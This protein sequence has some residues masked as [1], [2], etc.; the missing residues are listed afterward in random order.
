M[1]FGAASAVPEKYRRILDDEELVGWLAYRISM[2]SI[3]PDDKAALASEFKTFVNDLANEKMVGRLVGIFKRARGKE[4]EAVQAALEGWLERTAESGY[5]SSLVELLAAGDFPQKMRGHAEDALLRGIEACGRAWMPRPVVELL[6]KGGLPEEIYIR[7]LEVAGK[8]HYVDYARYMENMTALLER[9]WASP[10]LKAEAERALLE[11]GIEECL[12]RADPD[13]T[14]APLKNG[15]G[16]EVDKGR[17]VSLV[18]GLAANGNAGDAVRIKAVEAAVACHH[19]GRDMLIEALENVLEKEVPPALKEA[20]EKALE[21]C[22][23]QKFAVECA[24]KTPDELL[25][26]RADAKTGEKRFLDEAIIERF[27]EWARGG[28]AEELAAMLERKDLTQRLRAE[29]ERCLLEA[30]EACGKGTGADALFRIMGRAW[31]PE[32]VHAAAIRAIAGNPGACRMKF[33]E[34]LGDVLARRECPR[35]LRAAALE[36]LP[37]AVE[38]CIRG[39]EATSYISLGAAASLF[40]KSGVPWKIINRVAEECNGTVQWTKVVHLFKRNDLP[41]ETAAIAEKVLLESMDLSARDCL[42]GPTGGERGQIAYVVRILWEK[43]LPESAYLKGI[44]LCMKHPNVHGYSFVKALAEMFARSDATQKVR[45]A[46]ESALLGEEL[47]ECAAAGYPDFLLDVYKTA[48][49]PETVRERVKQI[50][51][52]KK[53]LEEMEERRAEGRGPASCPS[54]DQGFVDSKVRPPSGGRVKLVASAEAAPTVIRN[55]N[56]NRKPETGN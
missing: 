37:G 44:E 49:V 18:L 23:A 2:H 6:E 33:V 35:E 24:G 32:N 29:C 47:R 28:C 54:G 38:E 55:T 46:A 51:E 21:E 11:W 9:E 7:A 36:A 22:G 27:G 45:D 4:R 16:E 31:L 43:R 1:E 26:M 53:R 8:T 30:V 5:I 25:Q 41:P 40:R 12:E 42:A 50:L 56:G 13:D 34:A 19:V 48:G 20:V 3:S 52:I 17:L 39:K 15:K 14:R 10:R